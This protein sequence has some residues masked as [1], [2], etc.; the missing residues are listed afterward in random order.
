MES[1]DTVR[2]RRV[3]VVD[4]E[5][6]ICDTVATILED[7]GYSVATAVNGAALKV[8]ADSPPDVILLD[9]MMPLMDGP[10]VYRRLHLDPRTASIPVVVMTA[11]GNAHSWA[12]KLGATAAIQKPFA[13]DTLID[14][15]ARAIER[16]HD[17]LR[18][19]PDGRD[20]IG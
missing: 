8:A 12:R 18:L 11:A 1:V 6:A 17:D 5:D 15:V 2:Q 4:D 14:T 20:E 7:E 9:I 3:L 13:L 16:D 10:E 19:R